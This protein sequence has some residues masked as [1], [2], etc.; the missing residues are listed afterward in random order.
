MFEKIRY[1]SLLSLII[2]LICFKTFP[3]LA[4][5]DSFKAQISD[6]D[7]LKVFNNLWET[8]NR[9]Y[10]D[11]TFNGNDWRK[12]REVY[13]PK[14]LL[15]KNKVELRRTLKLMVG[16]LK[17][18]HLNVSFEISLSS[19][20]LKQLF[21]ENIDYKLN[22]ILFGYGFE[23]ADFDGETIVTKIEKKSAAEQADVKL[24]WIQKSCEYV[25]VTKEVGD[26]LVF[27]ETA[28]CIFATETEENK[29]I[30]M[31]QSWFLSPVS[32]NFRES[33]MIDKDVFYL[34]FTE[35]DKGSGKW[36][37]Q[38]ISANPNVKTVII[39]LRDNKGGLIDELK[40]ILS[41][42][43]PT[44]TVSGE[45]IERDLDEKKLSFGSENYYKGNVIV[46]INGSSYSSAEI[47]AAAIQDLGRGKIIGQTSG[48][49]VLSSLS[50]S[51]S[52]GFKLQIAFRD[53]KTVKGLRLEKKGVTPD[54]IIPFSI[55]DFRSQN[56]VILLKTLQYLKNQKD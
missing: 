42:F 9:L 22:A 44:K 46:L 1:K 49:K 23:T 7:K 38:Q 11:S 24:G 47:F 17:T 5:N 25:S 31:N 37:N 2:L 34:K 39:D 48:G 15:A 51:L 18:S 41:V 53:Y 21:G 36:L 20:N 40:N 16:E 43:F 12:L 29:S 6:S 45:F 52:S 27:G 56:D 3:V 10:F 35:F 50:K 8:V 19:K 54:I 55:K 32:K 33:K 30:T 14:I 26:S 4:Q 13:Q 28:N